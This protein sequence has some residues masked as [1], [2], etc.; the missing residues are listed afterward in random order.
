MLKTNIKIPNVN[1]D[2]SYRDFGRN[3]YENR[4]FTLNDLNISNRIFNYWK[5][6]EVIPWLPNHAKAKFNFIEATWL[7]VLEQLRKSGI[8][9]AA[10]RLITQQLILDAEKNKVADEVI[11]LNIGELKKDPDQHEDLIW[12]L[13]D[14]LKDNRLMKVL[15]KEITYL[16][17]L[18]KEILIE[19]SEG[20]I[21]IDQF[22]SCSLYN[23]ETFGDRDQLISI[24]SAFHIIVPLRPFINQL[25]TTEI[26]RGTFD[27]PFLSDE[28]MLVIRELRNKEVAELSVVK[29]NQKLL[30]KSSK[31]KSMPVNELAK[32]I[33]EGR[34]KGYDHYEI[35]SRPG[36]MAFVRLQKKIEK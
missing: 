9:I 33:L 17:Q 36:N 10:M 14:T 20:G 28:E 12:T 22:N 2:S 27:I 1:S 5:N 31:N 35:K 32:C 23:G 11:K 7:L 30:I 4:P 19:K 24:F 8:S 3:L 13:E 6:Y 25:I 15:R 16:S 21:I 34:F 18:V 26:E 29:Q